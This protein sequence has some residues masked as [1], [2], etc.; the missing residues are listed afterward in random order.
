MGWT[1]PDGIG[2]NFREWKICGGLHPPQVLTSSVQD[3]PLARAN[4]SHTTLD[5]I[6]LI[7]TAHI[8]SRNFGEFDRRLDAALSGTTTT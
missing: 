3:D 4:A 5:R 7:W 2:L 1:F 6:H 8:R